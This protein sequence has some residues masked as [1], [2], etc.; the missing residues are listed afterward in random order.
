MFSFVGQVLVSIGYELGTIF[1]LILQVFF[2]FNFSETMLLSTTLG[3]M[4][5]ASYIDLINAFLKANDHF[6]PS[7][8]FSLRETYG[9]LQGCPLQLHCYTKLIHYKYFNMQLDKFCQST[10]T[11]II[12]YLVYHLLLL[13]NYHNVL[14]SS[15]A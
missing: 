7:R 8:D 4:L 5:L 11:T 9:F 2:T 3:T 12:F 14:S 1:V 6:R 13:C 10:N 15:F